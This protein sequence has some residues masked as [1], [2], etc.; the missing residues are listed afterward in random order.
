MDA[1]SLHQMMYGHI[2]AQILYAT[3]ELGVADALADGPLDCADVAGRTATEVRTLRRLLRALVGLGVVEQFGADRFGLTETGGL[4]R[5]DAPGSVRDDLLLSVTPELWRAWGSLARSVRDGRAPRDP[6]TG[7]TAHQAA[8]R[9]PE[10]AARYRAAMARAGREFAAGIAEVYDFTRFGTLADLGGDEGVLLAEIL[11]A[12]PGLKGVLHDVPESFDRVRATMEAAG[13]EDR[14]E[15]AARAPDEPPG[16]GADAYLLNHLLHDRDDDA[17]T[18]LLRGCRTA[19]AADAVLLVVETVMP[20]VLTPGDSA[21]Y[22]MTDLNTMVH[23][24]GRERTAEEYRA[25]LAAAGFAL[26]AVT[27]VPTVGGLPSYSVIE[28]APAARPA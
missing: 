14:C 24:G 19:L 25:L 9:D 23:S 27:D 21:T 1:Q 5:S 3:A 4:L 13:T 17:A 8:L 15:L 18:A 2:P 28:A 22:G 6:A 16:R 20:P 12:N 11:S 10:T 26:T 7:L